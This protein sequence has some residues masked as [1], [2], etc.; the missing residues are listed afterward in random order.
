MGGPRD[1][2][3]LR[4]EGGVVDVRGRRRSRELKHHVS[5]QA[6]A[7]PRSEREWVASVRAISTNVPVI[8]HGGPPFGTDEAVLTNVAPLPTH[9]QAT[10]VWTRPHRR[11]RSA[12]AG[13]LRTNAVRHRVARSTR[14]PHG[15]LL[16]GRRPCVEQ[17]HSTC[18]QDPRRL[19]AGHDRP[20]RF[21]G[22]RSTWRGQSRAGGPGGSGW[23]GAAARTDQS[24]AERTLVDPLPHSVGGA[25]RTH[26]LPGAG[27]SC[28]GVGPAM[29]ADDRARLQPPPWWGQSREAGSELRKASDCRPF[30]MPEEGLEPST[31]G[32]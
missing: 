26:R 25:E 21:R 8:R 31:F 11:Q 24:A 23:H 19:V 16:A 2:C 20:V 5:F 13:T 30:S 28:R 4:R 1:H 14:R 27:A 17:D 15:D 9:S 3:L 6:E 7:L 12:R 32:L 10:W 29:T 22:A 18:G